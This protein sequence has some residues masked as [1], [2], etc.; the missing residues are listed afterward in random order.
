[1]RYVIEIRFCVGDKIWLMHNN[2]PK[3]S[4][5]IGIRIHGMD[6]DTR[7]EDEYRSIGFEYLLLGIPESC[8]EFEAFAS[9]K[10]LIESLM[11]EGDKEG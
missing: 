11:Q 3:K 6:L 2:R 7:I 5:I 10:E 9:K 4:E 1:M 8:Y